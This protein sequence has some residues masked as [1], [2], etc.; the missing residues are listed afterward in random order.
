MLKISRVFLF[1]CSSV[2]LGISLNSFSGGI[3]EFSP[4]FQSRF[5]ACLERTIRYSHGYCLCHSPMD[6]HYNWQYH[7]DLKRATV[8]C[9]EQVGREMSEEKNIRSEQKRL[10]NIEKCS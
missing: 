8:I 1:L 7:E 6:D 4:E 3:D 5:K 10:S 2:F 9:R